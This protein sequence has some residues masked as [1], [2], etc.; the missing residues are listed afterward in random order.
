MENKRLFGKICLLQKQMY[1]Q[2]CQL[3]GDTGVTPVQMNALWFIRKNALKG[4]KV[5][6]KDVEKHVGLCPS[7]VS[8]LLSNLEKDG[9]LLRTVA[10]GDARGKYLA[11]TGEGESLCLKN[12]MLMDK[13]DGAIQNALTDEEQKDLEKLLTKIINSVSEN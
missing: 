13:C 11:L 7:S 8:A 1:R 12:K 4:I 6:Q 9:Y 3:L 5:M 10:D 2:N